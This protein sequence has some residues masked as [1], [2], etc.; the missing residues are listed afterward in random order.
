MQIR[1]KILDLVV[2]VRLLQLTL[3]QTYLRILFSHFLGSRMSPFNKEP[4]W[5]ETPAV[6][7]SI[8]CSLHQQSNADDTGIGVEFSK[9]NHKEN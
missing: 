6:P 3:S 5:L 8:F 1:G 7:T 4:L 9:L 2:G